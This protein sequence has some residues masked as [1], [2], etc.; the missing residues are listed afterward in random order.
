MWTKGEKGLGTSTTTRS[1][2]VYFVTRPFH[3]PS[4][5]YTLP[6]GTHAGKQVPWT[7]SSNEVVPGHRL[8]GWRLV[9]GG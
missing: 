6:L 7:R 3:P 2:W 5:T 8:T 9:V 1:A 4:R